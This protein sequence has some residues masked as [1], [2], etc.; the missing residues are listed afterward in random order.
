[1]YV[2]LYIYTHIYIHTHTCIYT[3]ICINICIHMHI[4]N[5][6]IY[7][8]THKQTKI[9]FVNRTVRNENTL[10][11]VFLNAGLCTV[12]PTSLLKSAQ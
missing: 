4:I 7:I 8:Y 2:C 1:M 12:K 3:Y 9:H 5:I 10:H 11:R 6:Y